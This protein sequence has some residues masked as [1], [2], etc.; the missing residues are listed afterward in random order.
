[1]RKIK[2]FVQSQDSNLGPLT[3]QLE[4]KLELLSMKTILAP[5]ISKARRQLCYRV[6]AFLEEAILLR[7]SML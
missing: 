4:S 5:Y 7:V 6:R 2:G 1:M 3:P